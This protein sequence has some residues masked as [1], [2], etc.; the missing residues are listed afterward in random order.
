VFIALSPVG[1]FVNGHDSSL[2]TMCAIFGFLMVV[3]AYLPIPIF[4]DTFQSETGTFAI[5]N[6]TCSIIG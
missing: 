5:A 1:I 4:S 2:D 6:S 3:F